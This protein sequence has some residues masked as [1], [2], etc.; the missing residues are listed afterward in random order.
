MKPFVLTGCLFAATVLVA[1]QGSIDRYAIIS[2]G[3][4][5]MSG[6]WDTRDEGQIKELRAKYGTRFAWFRQDGRDFIVTSEEVMAELDEAMA[7]QRE[8][9]RHQSEVNHHQNDVNRM[10]AGVN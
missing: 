6:S 8:V 4:Q 5:S 3:S 10:Q 7:P 9:N 2:G 1:A